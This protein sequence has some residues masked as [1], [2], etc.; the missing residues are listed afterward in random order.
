MENKSPKSIHIKDDLHLKLKEIRFNLE[1]V[2]IERSLNYIHD[3]AVRCGIDNAF[4]FI[5]NSETSE[6]KP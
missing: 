1:K 2:G 5:K 4:E 3:I 6:G